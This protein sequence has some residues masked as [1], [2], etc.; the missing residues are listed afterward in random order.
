MK[1]R[2]VRLNPMTLTPGSCV[3][4]GARQ[5]QGTQISQFPVRLEQ[6]I[7]GGYAAEAKNPG[8]WE[9]VELITEFEEA[10]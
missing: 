10:P 5:L 8:R 1:L 4:M 7:P 6:W 3:L 2:L 9:E